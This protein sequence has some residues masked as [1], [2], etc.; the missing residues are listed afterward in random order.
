MGD[1]ASILEDISSILKGMASTLQEVA[2][3]FNL[4]INKLKL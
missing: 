4:K 3:F 1:V 2:S